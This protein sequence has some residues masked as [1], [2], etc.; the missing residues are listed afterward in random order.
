MSNTGIC[1]RC[2]RVGR[3]VQQKAVRA[4]GIVPPSSRFPMVVF[5]R[6]YLCRYHLAA[7]NRTRSPRQKKLKAIEYVENEDLLRYE[8]LK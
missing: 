3:L 6:L 1:E 4:T 8:K 5:T 7:W 2:T